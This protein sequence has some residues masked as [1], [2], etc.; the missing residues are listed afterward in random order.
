VS[1]EPIRREP[2]PR[3][4]TPGG[5]YSYGGTE[6]SAGSVAPRATVA[7][8]GKRAGR[9]RGGRRGGAFASR[10]HGFAALIVG[11]IAFVTAAISWP[12]GEG[13]YTVLLSTIGLIA[14][15]L[16]VAT[17]RAWRVGLAR[18]R[19]MA[20]T[21]LALG[22][23]SLVS[24]GVI[25]ANGW[26]GLAIPALPEVT[27]AVVSSAMQWGTASPSVGAVSDGP[28]VIGEPNVDVA[29]TPVFATADSE[30]ATISRELGTLVYVINNVA[31]GAPDVLWVTP[32]GSAHLSSDGRAFAPDNEW[33][34]TGY[35]RGDDGSYIITMTG[36]QHASV[37]YFHSLTGVIERR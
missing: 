2:G 7:A 17:L 10:D 25:L 19:G 6:T 23:V 26:F 11:L 28:A 9:P 8:P 4:W 5:G 12:A 20:R 22:V 29:A 18:R 15:A 24:S 30:F 27:R 35:A 3:D 1:P 36:R 37:A 13:G 34:T 31:N 32:T 33:V 21:G 14:V 16:G